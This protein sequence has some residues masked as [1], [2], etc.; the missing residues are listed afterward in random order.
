MSERNLRSESDTALLASEI[1][2]LFLGGKTIV[3]EGD[4][5]A[6]KTTLVRYLVAALGGR[7]VDV[8]SPTFALEHDYGIPGGLQVEHWDLYRLSAAPQELLEPPGPSA[9]RIIEWAS[10]CPGAAAY[11]D[12]VIS[13]TMKSEEERSVLLS[14]PLA[15]VF[16]HG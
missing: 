10:K 5:G 6:G 16:R 14:G 12:L 11:A 1:A 13:L 4:L 3:L 9:L 8:S 15:E 7:A 2:K